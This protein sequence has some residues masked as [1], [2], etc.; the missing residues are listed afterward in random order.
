MA[1]KKQSFLFLSGFIL[2]FLISLVV[3]S[4]CGPK[5]TWTPYAPTTIL[6]PKTYT[7][8]PTTTE[9]VKPHNSVLTLP[10][11]SQILLKPEADVNIVLLPGLPDETSDIT[12]Q[13]NSGEIMV[14]PNPDID[15]W[16]TVLSSRG[17]VARIKGCAMVV[18]FDLAADAYTMKCIGGDCEVGPDLEHKFAASNNQTWLFQG[19]GYLEPTDID[20]LQLVQEFGDVIPACVADASRNMTPTYV[21]SP[22]TPEATE[23]LAATATAACSDFHKKF[24]GT[25]CP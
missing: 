23:D 21:P 11:G 6:A 20:F 4:G 15:N 12:L 9:V 1:E 24:P 16:I 2:V 22:L 18:N 10:D 7:P 3:I 25:P 8:S 17:Y 5:P 19:G 14:V 13:L